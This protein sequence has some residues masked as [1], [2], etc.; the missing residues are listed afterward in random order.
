MQWMPTC[1][2]MVNKIAENSYIRYHPVI[3]LELRDMDVGICLLHTLEGG[4][5]PDNFNI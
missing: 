3:K 4:D 5:I 1:M 2:H